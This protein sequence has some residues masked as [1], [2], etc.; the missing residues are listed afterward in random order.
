M[1][2]C[3]LTCRYLVAMSF[4]DPQELDVEMIR[5]RLNALDQKA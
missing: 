1:S 5:Q 3:A 4:R 2:T